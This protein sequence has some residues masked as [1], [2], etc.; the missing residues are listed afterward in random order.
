MALN[1]PT[2]PTTNQ[3]YSYGGS[4]WIWTSYAWNSFT[5]TGIYLDDILDVNISSP[6]S[7]Q[8]LVYDGSYWMSSN[9]FASDNTNN[10][11][12]NPTNNPASGL[13]YI[14]FTSNTSGYYPLRTDT[15]LTW[16]PNTN[17]LV[18]GSGNGM[19]SAI[20]DGGVY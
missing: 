16:N 15:D 7:G 10:V 2:T 12:L 11:F 13:Y 8:A 19:I 5:S 4:S 18:L 9:S 3:I 1:F 17:L 20:I 14:N 6:S